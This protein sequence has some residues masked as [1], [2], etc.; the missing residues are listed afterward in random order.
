[1]TR[2]DFHFNT[3]DK[4]AYACRLLRKAYRSNTRVW[5]CC[6]DA[7]QRDRLDRLLWTFA[8]LEFIPHVAAGH[9]LAVQTPIVLADTLEGSED[10]RVAVHLG[11]QVPEG[12]SSFERWI[13][14][15]A[16]DEEDRLLA[17]ARWSYFKSH[18]YP[19]QRFDQQKVQERE[20]PHSRP[21]AAGPADAPLGR[22]APEAKASSLIG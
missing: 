13:E 21:Q 12:F 4:L 20:S 5:V 3:S 19:M 17:R 7:H 2:I 18:G 1:M 16:S 15:V 10:W 9:R 6:R 11:D 14:V 22:V 8:P